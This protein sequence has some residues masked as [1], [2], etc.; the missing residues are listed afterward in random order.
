MGMFSY[1]FISARDL[2][3]ELKKRSLCMDIH[4]NIRYQDGELYGEPYEEP[5]ENR[6]QILDL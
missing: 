2:E 5:I 6:W 4:G 1:G 3:E